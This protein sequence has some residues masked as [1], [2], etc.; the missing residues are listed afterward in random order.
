MAK[1]QIQISGIAVEL[2]LGN[3]MPKD[4][5]IFDN[6][7]DFYHF[8][9]LIHESQLLTEHISE[10]IIKQ[11]E[12]I[13]YKGKIPDK[14]FVSQKSFLPAMQDHVLYLRTECAENATFQYEFET[15]HFDKLK[16]VFETQD[17]DLIFKVGKPFLSN[18]VY[19]GNPIH[20]EWLNGKPI[21][22]ICVLC[23]FENGYLVPI[24]DAVNKI[25]KI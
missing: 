15:D 17:Y 6:W 13:I 12:Q 5:T 24:Y 16:L 11:D 25:G 4:A 8:D 22:N 1:I 18:V 21:G 10:I 14:Q 2:A 3:Y 20:Q 23:R 9:N 7:E 19:D